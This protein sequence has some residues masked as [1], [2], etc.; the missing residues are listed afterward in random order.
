MRTHCVAAALAVL[1]AGVLLGQVEDPFAGTWKLN[2]EK[3]Q[4]ARPVQSATM[5]L[6]IAI[7]EVDIPLSVE[8][9][10]RERVYGDG[11]REA[12]SYTARY[13]GSDYHIVNTD[14]GVSIQEEARLKMIDETTREL[15]RLKNREPLSTSRRVLSADGNTLTVTTTLPDGTIQDIEVWDRQ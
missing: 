14:T 8:K 3:S 12:I 6:R 7:D 10:D 13:A 1:T 5:R 2:V 15:S 4:L 11:S 9:M